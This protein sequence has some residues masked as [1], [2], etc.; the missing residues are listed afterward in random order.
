VRL[1][2]GSGRAREGDGDQRGY[3]DARDEGSRF[4]QSCKPTARCDEIPPTLVVGREPLSV[5]QVEVISE[6]GGQVCQELV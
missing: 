3:E 1:K 2:Q 4:E 6:S 5:G